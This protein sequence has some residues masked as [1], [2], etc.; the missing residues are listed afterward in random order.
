MFG[1]F[2]GLGKLIHPDEDALAGLRFNHF[3]DGLGLEYD[4]TRDD[5]WERRNSLLIML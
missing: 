5:L 1:C 3:T 4:S 2:Y